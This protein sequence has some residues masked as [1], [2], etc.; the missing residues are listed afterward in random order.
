MDEPA[1]VSP[2]NLLEM[3]IVID[4][5]NRPEKAAPVPAAAGSSINQS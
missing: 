1:N 4:P 2:Q 5:S 3:S